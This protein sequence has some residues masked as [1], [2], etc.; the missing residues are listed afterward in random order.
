MA[1]AV[2]LCAVL[3]VGVSSRTIWRSL[4]LDTSYDK[5][6]GSLRGTLCSGSKINTCNLP[7]VDGLDHL[8][9]TKIQGNVLKQLLGWSIFPPL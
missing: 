2:G 5:V 1:A 6:G 7:M 4:S 9:G 8:A 3:C